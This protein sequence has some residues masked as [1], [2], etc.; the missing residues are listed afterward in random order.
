M[1]NT[2]FS[3]SFRCRI[4]ITVLVFAPNWLEDQVCPLDYDIGGS[5]FFLVF[6]SLIPIRRDDIAARHRRNKGLVGKGFLSRFASQ[7][8]HVS[9]IGVRDLVLVCRNRLIF[10]R[11]L[12]FVQGNRLGFAVV[13]GDRRVQ[14][15][16]RL[17]LRGV[18]YQFTDARQVIQRLTGGLG[19][20]SRHR[21][22]GV[23]AGNRGTPC[24]RSLSL[25]IRRAT[26][27]AYRTGRSVDDRDGIL[28]TAQRHSSILTLGLN[29]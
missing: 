26:E 25:R 4:S 5:K 18:I 3:D 6:L 1:L 8:C 17:R 23:Q 16:D 7:T 28:H 9:H 22:D 24:V 13:H 14:R 29:A 15:I 12:P 20:G 2:N 19:T 21:G 10:L 11:H 27:G